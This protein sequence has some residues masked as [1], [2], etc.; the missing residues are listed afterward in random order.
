MPLL[1]SLAIDFNQKDIEHKSAVGGCRASDD[2]AGV[3]GLLHRV[4]TINLLTAKGSVPLLVSCFVCLNQINIGS[5]FTVGVCTARDDVAAVRGLLYRVGYINLLTTKNPVP[6][7]DP[8]PIS[9]D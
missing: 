8:F 3:R 9:L 1:V 7:F 6:L 2:V 5:I 4:G